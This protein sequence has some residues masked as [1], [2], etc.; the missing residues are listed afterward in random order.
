M[1]KAVIL[2]SALLMT[3]FLAFAQDAST[4]GNTSNQ[5]SNSTNGGAIRGCLSGSNGAYSLT[6]QQTGTV[7]SLTGKT[8]ALAQHVGHEVEIIGQKSDAAASESSA[9]AGTN[10]NAN[11]SGTA[12]N[13]ASVT[14]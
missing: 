6:D 7:F 10:A 2:F 13:S 4:T 14:I 1:K 12:S 11:P 3:A 5:T 8:D 9:A